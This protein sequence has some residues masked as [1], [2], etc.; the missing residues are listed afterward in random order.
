MRPNTRTQVICVWAGPAAILLF[1]VGFAIAGFFPPHSPSFD[2]GQIAEIYRHHT[3]Q[4]RIGTIIMVASSGLVT[5]FAAVVAIHMRRIEGRDAPVLSLTQFAAGTTGIMM[6]LTEAMFWSIAAYR[7][8]R[9]PEATQVLND[10]AWFFTVMPF[11]LIVVQALCVAALILG[12]PQDQTVFPRWL[13]Y[14]NLWAALLYIPGG[15]MT[16][17]HS[18]PLA[19][20]GIF[21]FWVPATVYCAWFSTMAVQITKSV[22][23]QH[24]GAESLGALA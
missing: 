10:I 19:W 8:E 18:G 16:L 5:P 15:T 13:G 24:A 1:F 21:A 6:F 20:N 3:T 14:F 12:G 23:R 11:C 7:P 17:F 2:A 22:R 9:S 4:I